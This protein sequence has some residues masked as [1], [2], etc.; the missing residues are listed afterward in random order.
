[1][2][3]WKTH[4]PQHCPTVT[5]QCFPVDLQQS[6][7]P[8]HFTSENSCGLLLLIA[9]PLLSVSDEADCFEGGDPTFELV[10]PVVQGGLGHQHHVGSGDAPVVL[11]VPQQRDGLQG[12]TQ[13]LKDNKQGE[14]IYKNKKLTII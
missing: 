13:T 4:K 11:H 10:H 2:E 1:M 7:C 6:T 12:L 3:H 8:V 14:S 5:T 9:H